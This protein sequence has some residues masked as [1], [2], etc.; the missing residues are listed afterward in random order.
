MRLGMNFGY[1]D[2]GAG[3]P[4]AVAQAQEAERLGYD[5]VWTAEA[6]GTDSI[7]PLTWLLAHTERIRGGSAIMQMPARTPA[8]TAMTA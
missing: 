8:M 5:S 4:N 1:Q 3:L 6:Y 2:W 7:T